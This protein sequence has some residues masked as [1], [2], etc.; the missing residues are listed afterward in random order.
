VKM[1]GGLLYRLN[2]IGSTLRCGCLLALTFPSWRKEWSGDH[3]SKDRCILVL[4]H[5]TNNPATSYTR[6]LQLTL[7]QAS[8]VANPTIP[9]SPIRTPLSAFSLPNFSN[10]PLTSA[11]SCAELSL[12]VFS[13]GPLTSV[14]WLKSLNC[15][16]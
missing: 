8:A 7:H 6:L 3:V 14:N 12:P 13:E 5:R 11:S 4:N 15:P 1:G 16:V 2:R 10:N 9:P